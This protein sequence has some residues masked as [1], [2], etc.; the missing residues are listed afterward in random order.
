MDIDTKERVA[1]TRKAND[2]FQTT[3]K[4]CL[5]QALQHCPIWSKRPHLHNYDSFDHCD[6]EVCSS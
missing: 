4:S 2:K 5:R 6:K 3:A 1:L